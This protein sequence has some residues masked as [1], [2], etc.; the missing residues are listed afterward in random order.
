VYGGHTIGI[1]A[2]HICRV[3]PDLVTIVGWEA[4]DHIAPVYEGDVLRSAIALID[5]DAL[6]GGGGLVHLRA[7]VQAHRKEHQPTE[8]LDWRLVGVMA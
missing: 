4:C 3:L 7:R 5:V 1:A 2:S 6:P 8:V